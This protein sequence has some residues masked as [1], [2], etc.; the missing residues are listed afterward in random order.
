MTVFPL[1]PPWLPSLMASL[2][3]TEFT[4]NLIEQKN[5]SLDSLFNVYSVL[6]EAVKSFWK[7]INDNI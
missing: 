4:F 6:L 2:S 7:L 3:P 1:P 5:A